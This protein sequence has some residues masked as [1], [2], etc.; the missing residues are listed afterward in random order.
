[1]YKTVA[2]DPGFGNTKIC[3]EGRSALIQ[4]AVVRPREVGM[5]AIGMRSASTITRVSF[6]GITFGVG[7]GAWAWGEVR[8]GMDFSFLSSPERRALMYATLSTLIAPG[9]IQIDLLVIGLPV[10]LLQD[11]IQ[12]ESVLN[13]LKGLKGQHEFQVN[14]STYRVSIEKIKVLAQPAGA[15]FDWLLDEQLH[16]RKAASQSEVA[17]LD[18]GMNTAD[19]YVIQGG[20]VQPR[21]V[22][23]GKVGVRRLLQIL[24]NDGHDMEE[25]D[26]NLRNHRLKISQTALIDWQAEIL[27]V[28]ERTWPSLRRFTSIIP[29]GGGA[30]ILKDLLQSALASKGAAIHWPND[31]ISTNVTGLWKWGEYVNSH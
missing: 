29:A 9:D 12:T 11:V 30:V 3:L 4:S 14:D 13:G 16:P 28:I 24:M 23:G 6:N 7:A 15:Y 20:V 10:P 21:F 27:A 8:G 17:V 22:G 25:L 18:L 26:A 1:M 19:L 31:P 5:A 2:L